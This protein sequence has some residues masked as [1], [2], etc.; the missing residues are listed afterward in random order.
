MNV[1]RFGLAICLLAALPPAAARAQQPQ[2]AVVVQI[3]GANLYLDAGTD[4]GVHTGDTLSVRRSLAAQPVGAC[5][6]IASTSGRSV[7]TFVGTPFPATR[8]DT[9]YITPGSVAPVVVAGAA[10]PETR[11]VPP[12]AIPYAVRSGTRVD[13]ALG[14]EMWGARTTTLGLGADPVRSTQDVATPAV[15]L[16]TSIAGGNSAFNLNLRAQHRAGPQG[17]FQPVTTVRIYDARF[18]QTM[19]AL[20]LSVGRFFSDFDHASGYWDGAAVRVGRERGLSAGVAGGFEPVLINDAFST[21]VPKVA[22]FV[23]ARG[24]TA[25]ATFATDLAFHQTLPRNAT[26]KRRIADWSLR[27]NAR[28]LGL[29]QEIEVSPDS[30]GRN[31]GISR[32]ILRAFAPIGTGLDIYGSAV[33]DRPPSVDTTW[34]LPLERRERVTGG[35]SYQASRNRF[36]ADLNGTINGPRETTRGYS[37]GALFAFPNLIGTATIAAGGSYFS[38]GGNRGVTANPSIEYRIGSSRV[39]AGYQ[40]FLSHGPSYSVTTHGGDL[41]WSQSISSRVEWVMQFNVRYGANLRST[42]GYSSLEVRF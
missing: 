20:Q 26:P 3:A 33:S 40:F 2:R 35:V 34:A 18:D 11:V 8:G 19:G 5:T 15:R 4:A 10:S 25:R 14:L 42:S 12:R 23:S 39:R 29:A 27:V 9:L 17:L 30:A 13:G 38:R 36:Y 31:W 24:R 41:R 22:G 32:Y 28:R 1:R 21:D 16:R 37:A 7:V 6:V